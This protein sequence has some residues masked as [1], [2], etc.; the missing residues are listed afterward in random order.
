MIWE[1]A[2]LLLVVLAATLLYRRLPSETDL[3]HRGILRVKIKPAG[4]VVFAKTGETQHYSADHA[5]VDSG[6]PYPVPVYRLSSEV[7]QAAVDLLRSIG[8][9][10]IEGALTEAERKF[11]RDRVA[12]LCSKTDR[13]A[14]HCDGRSHKPDTE[15]KNTRI[16]PFV[17][18]ARRRFVT[19]A[20]STLCG[21]PS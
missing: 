14:E 11:C 8:Y 9:C 6:K 4:E 1:C 10:V 12:A 17:I 18:R 2:L 21:S 20:C 3:L 5:R 13:E 16:V 15:V 7:K 19:G